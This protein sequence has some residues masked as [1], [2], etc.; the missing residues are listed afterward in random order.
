MDFQWLLSFPFPPEPLPSCPTP[1]LLPLLLS[2]PS[3]PAFTPGFHPPFS[4]PASCSLQA[5]TGGG[6]AGFLVFNTRSPVSDMRRLIS[7][8]V[9]P[10][11]AGRSHSG[12]ERPN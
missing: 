4:S 10:S 9:P 3:S 12:S 2:A 1:P 8:P 7:A 6:V 11:E 5:L